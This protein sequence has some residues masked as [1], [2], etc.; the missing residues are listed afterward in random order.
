MTNTHISQTPENEAL[1]AELSKLNAE[2]LELFTL[3][4]KIW[5]TRSR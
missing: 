3:A 1:S 5:W 4:Q 2:F